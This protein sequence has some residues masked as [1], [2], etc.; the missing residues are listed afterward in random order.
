MNATASPSARPVA[1]RR[2]PAAR[3]DRAGLIRLELLAEAVGERFEVGDDHDQAPEAGRAGRHLPDA[4]TSSRIAGPSRRKPAERRRRRGSR[5]ERQPRLLERRGGAVEVG[6][7][8][9]RRGRCRSRRSGVGGLG[10]GSRPVA[11]PSISDRRVAP[12]RPAADRRGLVRRGRMLTPPSRSTA[13]SMTS[14]PSAA[15]RSGRI[16][17]PQRRTR[18]VGFTASASSRAP[19]RTR[20]PSS[21][22]SACP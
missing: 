4:S 3:L 15:H 1:Q 22:R 16:R 20:R 5:R 21:A 2:D 17:D 13:P 11:G 12:R 6:R 9:R 8:R 7:D 10:R 14:N 18:V 19:A